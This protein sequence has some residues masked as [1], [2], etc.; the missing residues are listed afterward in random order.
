MTRLHIR[1][2]ICMGVG[3]M[4][5]DIGLKPF[6][7]FMLFLIVW[8]YGW[9]S[10]L[11]VYLIFGVGYIILHYVTKGIWYLNTKRKNYV[12][13]RIMRKVFGNDNK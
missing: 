4:P 9:A 5:N 2:Q 12:T 10:L 11:V 6:I 13:K 8:V 7:L 3:Y 1:K